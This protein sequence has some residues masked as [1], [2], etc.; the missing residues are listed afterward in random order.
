MSPLQLWACQTALGSIAM[1]AYWT[2]YGADLTF[3]LI[4]NIAGGFI[5]LLIAFAVYEHKKRRMVRDAW[6]NL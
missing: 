1:M 4:S 5:A 6:K 2:L 3:L